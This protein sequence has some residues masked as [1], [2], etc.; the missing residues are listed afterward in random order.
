L[1]ELYVHIPT[2]LVTPIPII[3]VFFELQFVA[4]VVIV[5]PRDYLPLCLSFQFLV[6]LLFGLLGLF[7]LSEVLPEDCDD[8]G[9][10]GVVSTDVHVG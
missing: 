9:V 7:A 4:V 1:A 2:S 5:V 10:E 8:V 6:D 3:A